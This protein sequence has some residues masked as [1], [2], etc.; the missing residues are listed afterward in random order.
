MS[1]RPLDAG[2]FYED[3][4]PGLP[5][6]RSCGG[7]LVRITPTT[8]LPVAWCAWCGTALAGTAWHSPESVL[9]MTGAPPHFRR[10]SLP[11]FCTRETLVNGERQKCE[12]R[13][14]TER[15]AG[16]WFCDEHAATDTYGR[17]PDD[18]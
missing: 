14:T 6:C 11:L 1:D 16:R 5:D 12:R 2:D 13:A 3:R 18:S 4:D 17:L 8:G 7:E 9:E 10:R 15:G